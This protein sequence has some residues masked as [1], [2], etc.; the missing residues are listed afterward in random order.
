MG[1]WLHF[2]NRFREVVGKA[3][4]KLVICADYRLLHPMA[5]D[6][7]NAWLGGLREMNPKLERSALLL[8]AGAPAVRLQIERVLREAKHPGRRACSDAAEVKAW[9]SSCLDSA[10]QARLTQFLAW[11][12]VRPK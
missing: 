3:H 4:G 10:E 11:T 7:A 6:I 9:L 5:P 2:S 8:P 12:A 1:S